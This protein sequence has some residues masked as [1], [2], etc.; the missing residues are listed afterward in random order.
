MIH[1]ENLYYIETSRLICF[2]NQWTGFYG[3]S[4]MKELIALSLAMLNLSVERYGEQNHL[5]HVIISTA[6]I[7]T[8]SFFQNSFQFYVVNNSNIS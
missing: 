7:L 2:E 8:T 5:F 3:T 1:N 6:V 4:A